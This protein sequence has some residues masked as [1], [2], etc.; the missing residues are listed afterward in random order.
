MKLV[1]SGHRAILI[2]SAKA[3]IAYCENN[4]QLTY[5][6]NVKGTLELAYQADQLGLSVIFLSSDYVFDGDNA[7]YK[8]TDDTKPE[9]EYGRQKAAVEKMLPK[10]VKNF[11]ILRLGK[12]Y[13]VEKNDGTLLDEIYRHLILS[14]PIY[15]ATDQ[16]FCPTFIDD[17][18]DVIH[19]LQ[20]AGMN[21]TF[22]VCNPQG[23][24]RYGIALLMADA[25]QVNRNLV[26]PVLLHS[27][28]SMNSRPLDT[29]MCPSNLVVNLKPEFTSLQVN[30]FKVAQS[31]LSK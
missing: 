12:I 23:F 14:S 19:L 10:I 4:S 26:Q 30:V 28:P 1:E 20:K 27:I 5:D 31:W 22:N 29:R 24:S 15:Y 11:M 25:M 7:P 9:T 3:N 2:A 21:G 18:V 6:I 8:D 13:G 17:L 16:M